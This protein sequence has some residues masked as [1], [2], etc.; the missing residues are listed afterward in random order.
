M[1]LRRQPDRDSF[2]IANI[3]ALPL[4]YDVV[5]FVFDEV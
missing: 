4:E 1:A 2:E 3:C 5:T